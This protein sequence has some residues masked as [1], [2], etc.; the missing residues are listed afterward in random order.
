MSVSDNQHQGFQ[1]LPANASVLPSGLL[2]G[3]FRSLLFFWRHGRFF[4]VFFV[5]FLLFAH[6]FRS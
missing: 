3:L 1:G 5:A 4:L 6:S 2:L